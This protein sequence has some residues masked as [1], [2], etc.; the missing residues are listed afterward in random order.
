MRAQPF[1][2]SSSSSESRPASNSFITEALTRH[3]ASRPAKSPPRAMPVT[4][5]LPRQ[6]KPHKK[7]KYSSP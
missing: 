2:Q 5:V 1:K 3:A 6:P 7:R 4:P